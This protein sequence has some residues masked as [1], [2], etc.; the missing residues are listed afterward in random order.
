MV[1]NLRKIS[2]LRNIPYVLIVEQD[3]ANSTQITTDLTVNSGLQGLYFFR[4]DVCKKESKGIFKRGK[5]GIYVSVTGNLVKNRRIVFD[6]NLFTLT[7]G[8]EA[9]HHTKTDDDKKLSNP[10]ANNAIHYLLYE[11][12]RCGWDEQKHK[13]HGKWNNQNDDTAIALQM[14]C[15]W[16]DMIYKGNSSH[17]PQIKLFM[18]TFVPPSDELDTVSHHSTDNRW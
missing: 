6:P 5:S 15:F 1:T 18:N 10:D 14:L 12:L 4:E 7:L 2:Y 3:F 13:Y 9:E 8:C 11:M 17:Y 16:M